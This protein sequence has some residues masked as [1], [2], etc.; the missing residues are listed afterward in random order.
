MRIGVLGGG[1]LAQMLALA[2]HPLGLRLEFI[3][4][5]AE[6]CA[7]SVAVQHQ[8]AFDD[9]EALLRLAERVDCITYE[10]ENVPSRSLEFLAPRCTVYPPLAALALG[11][12]RLQEN[13]LFRQL[14][15]ATPDFV[16]IDGLDDLQRGMDQIGLPALLKIRR[17]G[18]DGKGQAVIRQPQDAAAAWAA[19]GQRAAIL[20]ALVPF[21]REVSIIA[22]RHPGGEVRCYPLTEN[23]HR[24]G[25]L[26]RSIARPDDPMQPLAEEYI[27]RLLERLDYVGVLALELF[28]LGDRLLANEFAPRV[29]NSGHWTLNGA[30]TSQFENHLRAVAGLPLGS[31]RALG[32]SAMLNCIGRMPP[33]AEV[34]TIEGAHLHDYGKQGRPGRKLGHINLSAPD[35]AALEQ[36][37]AQAEA[38]LQKGA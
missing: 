31:P 10:F 30:E 21:E 19:I 29:H 28:Q 17:E 27:G 1:Q 12:D 37:L 26:S 23:T 2:G 32:P 38:I 25:I 18:Y 6:A 35:G 8:A 33:A 15:I 4:P 36:A 24:Q 7:A 14:D 20:E 13:S 22:A 5:S 16:A 34:L 3:D 9:L 11:Q